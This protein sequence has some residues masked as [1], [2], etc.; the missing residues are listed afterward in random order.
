MVRL[1]EIKM[2]LPAVAMQFQFLNGSIKSGNQ[3][4]GNDIVNV[5]QFLNGSIK[6]T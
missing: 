5:F 4:A 2:K 3:V 6:S 1:K